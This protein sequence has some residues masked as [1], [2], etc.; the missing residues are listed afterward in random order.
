MAYD[1]STDVSPGTP[2]DPGDHPAHNKPQ[3][4]QHYAGDVLPINGE[5]SMGSG[6]DSRAVDYALGKSK[7]P[8]VIP[9]GNSTLRNWAV[10]QQGK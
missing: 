3:A 1:S 9:I 4:T 2:M 10:R 7:D 5:Q 6:Q 8:K